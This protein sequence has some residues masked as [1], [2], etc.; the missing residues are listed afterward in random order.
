MFPIPDNLTSR[1]FGRESIK[2][3]TVM[4]PEIQEVV[5][6]QRGVEGTIMENIKHKENRVLKWL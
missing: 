4:V 2:A 3:S 6:L 5:F 1:S